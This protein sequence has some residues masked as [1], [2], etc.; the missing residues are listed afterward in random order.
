[1]PSRRPVRPD[2]TPQK[3]SW[4]SIGLAVVVGVG[5]FSVLMF[6]TF[7]FA[8]LVLVAAIG[9]FAF[10]AFHYLLWGWWLSKSIHRQVQEEEDYKRTAEERAKD[11]LP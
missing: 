8:A 1:M 6:L 7:Q 5:L 2:P 9:I 4:M 11:M 3:S 10:S